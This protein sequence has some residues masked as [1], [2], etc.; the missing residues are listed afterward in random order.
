MKLAAIGLGC[1][2]AMTPANMESR[3]GGEGFRQ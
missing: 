1:A 2:G 3:A